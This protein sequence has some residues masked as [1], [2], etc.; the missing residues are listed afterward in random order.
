[1]TDR[2]QTPGLVA[3][4]SLR[5]GTDGRARSTERSLPD[6]MPVA[7]VVD[8]ATFA[9]MLASPVGLEAFAIG[10]SLSERIV[11]SIAD[12]AGVDIVES[13]HGLE[14]RIWLAP[15][16]GARVAAGR[17]ALVGPTGCGLCGIESLAASMPELAAVDTAFTVRPA[18]VF[19]AVEA[20]GVA[21]VMNRAAS[22]LHA[23]GYWVPGAGLVQSAEDVGRHNALDKLIGGLAV[24][25]EHRPG[26]V[27]MTSRLSVELVH[28]CAVLGA[29]VMIALSV[30][31]A[32]AIERADVLGITLVA[33]ARADSFEVFTHP[34]RIELAPQGCEVDVHAA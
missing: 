17:R 31:T 4:R 5:I 27:V 10:F 1:M 30:P 33:V 32:L 13:D 22:A 2:F 18:D 21:Q 8:G 28:K 19:R 3:T 25:E 24:A 12:I 11:P 14:A 16:I 15:G 29:P 23:A 9:V 7:V 26:A 20:L 6:E 34:D